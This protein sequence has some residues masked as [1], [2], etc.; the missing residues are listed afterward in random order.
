MLVRV[1]VFVVVA[2][3]LVVVDVHGSRLIAVTKMI[4]GIAW[5]FVSG[6]PQLSPHCL[7][8]AWVIPCFN[9]LPWKLQLFQ[10][11]KVVITNK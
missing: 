6:C 10:M 4:G 9:F 8:H 11:E 2:G 7:G 3:T 1:V 5:L